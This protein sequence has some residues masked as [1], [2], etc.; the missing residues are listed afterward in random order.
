MK[1]DTVCQIVFEGNTYEAV[2]ENPLDW[3]LVQRNIQKTWFS[4]YINKELS[5]Y[6]LVKYEALSTKFPTTFVLYYNDV[7]IPLMS[8]EAQNVDMT[9]MGS[10]YKVLKKFGNNL[11]ISK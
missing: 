2:M 5:N 11:E 3:K 6:Q 9:V 8:I 7:E 1:K 10:I 4:L